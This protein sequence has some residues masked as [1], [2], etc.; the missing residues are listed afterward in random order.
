MVADDLA[1]EVQCEKVDRNVENESINLI[2][3]DDRKPLRESPFCNSNC[4]QEF[5]W[6]KSFA[7]HY[8][9]IRTVFFILFVFFFIYAYLNSLGWFSMV[10]Y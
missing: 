3:F 7:C 4:F 8:N 2:D 9:T 6:L 5:S 10:V 1:Y